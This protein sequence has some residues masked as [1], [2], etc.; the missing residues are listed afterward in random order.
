[1]RDAHT[2]A[3]VAWLS[4]GRG[5]SKET[6][7]AARQRHSAKGAPFTIEG[8]SERVA[9]RPRRGL[10]L[11]CF[12]LNAPA[13]SRRRLGEMAVEYLTTHQVAE[14]LHVRMRMVARLL[15]SGKLSG[16]KVNNRWQVPAAALKED[17]L[18]APARRPGPG[19]RWSSRRSPFSQQPVRRARKCRQDSFRYHQIALPVRDAEHAQKRRADE[20]SAF[21][22]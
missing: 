6:Y 3:K 5:G 2:A 22:Q 21:S 10:G 1:M 14:R 16:T 8:T 11:C 9:S 15:A 17:I 19:G 20:T 18:A 13:R 7:I 4:S 12:G